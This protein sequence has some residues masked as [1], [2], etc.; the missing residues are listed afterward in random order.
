MGR[1]NKLIRFNY[2]KDCPIVLE[3]GK[4]MFEN[5][6]GKWHSE[7]FKNDNP[8]VLEVGCG[9]GDYTIGLGEKFPDKNYIGID[10]KGA[11][12]FKGAKYAID[13]GMN[14][15]AFLRTQIL[16]LE[17]FFEKGEVDEIWLTFP[18]PRPLDGDEKRRLFS[19]RFLGIYKTFLKEG[20]ILNLK[21]DNY[22]LYTYALEVCEDLKITPITATDDLYDSEFEDQCHGIQTTYERRYLAEGIKINYL[23]I[24]L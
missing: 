9:R 14:N 4:E 11:R 23:K 8:I 10:I 7:M 2:L 15:V 1:R 3:H 16:L 17:K 13:S 22:G 24:S 20:G 5:I 21:T 19:P 18:D 12:I 6:K